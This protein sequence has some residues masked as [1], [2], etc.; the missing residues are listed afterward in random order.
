MSQLQG[1][2]VN[3]ALYHHLRYNHFP[4]VH[5]D[6]IPV[7]ERAIELAQE[8]IWMDEQQGWDTVIEMPNG[9]SLT[10]SEIVEGLHLDF[11]LEADEEDR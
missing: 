10:V 6:F 2:D 11:F 5:E 7:A 1:R 4:P 9:V 8:A 3:V